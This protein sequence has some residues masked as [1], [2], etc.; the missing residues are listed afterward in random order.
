[1]QKFQGGLEKLD[2]W[3]NLFSIKPLI[4]RIPSDTPREN[5]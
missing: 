5:Y 3:F 4:R 1:M 2:L